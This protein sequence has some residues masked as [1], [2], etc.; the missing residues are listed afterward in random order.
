MAPPRALAWI[1]PWMVAV[2]LTLI[3]AG[4]AT[5]VFFS[6]EAQHRRDREDVRSWEARA[7][8]MAVH[9]RLTEQHVAESGTDVASTR[10]SLLADRSALVA[11]AV[12]EIVRPAARAYI[13]AID[14]TLA[15]LDAYGTSGFRE[16]LR[17][18]DN[19]FAQAEATERDL[20]CRAG[21]CPRAGP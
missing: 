8:P 16:A 20:S 13:D 3:A 11:A 12:D 1:R 6:G 5:A 14:K 15:A 2:V 10:A 17:A 21:L 19:A 9:A 7:L 4:G 18:A